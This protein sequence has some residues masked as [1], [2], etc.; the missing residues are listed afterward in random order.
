MMAD[1]PPKIPRPIATQQASSAY[2]ETRSNAKR[3]GVA[4]KS[5]HYVQSGTLGGPGGDK[6]TDDH[7]LVRRHALKAYIKKGT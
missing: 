5:W 1:Q 7:P 3:M 6:V 4:E 2:A